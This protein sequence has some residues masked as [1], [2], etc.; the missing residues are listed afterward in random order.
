MACVWDHVA[1]EG[2]LPHIAL[3]ETMLPVRRLWALACVLWHWVR[4]IHG[5]CTHRPHTKTSAIESR[6]KALP[7]SGPSQPHGSSAKRRD[8]RGR[9]STPIARVTA[10]QRD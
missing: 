8:L 2:Y 7:K 1:F 5:K 3:S 6:K 4:S 10:K 9:I